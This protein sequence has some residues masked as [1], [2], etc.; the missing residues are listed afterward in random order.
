MMIGDPT[1]EQIDGSAAVFCGTITL[2]IPSVI[3]IGLIVILVLVGV[4]PQTIEKGM[5][6]LSV[7]W[8]AFCYAL[9]KLAHGTKVV[10]MDEDKSNIEI[11]PPPPLS[12][13]V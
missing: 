2:G 10:M 13:E 9:C 11:H 6:W 4:S 7:P 5:V 1:D 12:R 3:A 8:F